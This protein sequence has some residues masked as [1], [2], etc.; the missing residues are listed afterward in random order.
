MAEVR[1]VLRLWLRG[2]AVRA[3][4]RLSQDRA[5]RPGPLGRAHRP[6]LHRPP[7]SQR[8]DREEQRLTRYEHSG[9]VRSERR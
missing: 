6:A 2:H 1:E 8:R 9:A 3:I 4:A 5:A 7:A